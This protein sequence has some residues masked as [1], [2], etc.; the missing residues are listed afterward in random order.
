MKESRKAEMRNTLLIFYVMFLGAFIC[1]DS[2]LAQT[3]DPWTINPVLSLN[4]S[5]NDVPFGVDS[6][7][8]YLKREGVHL[9]FP[10]VSNPALLETPE[11][12]SIVPIRV[13]AW[14]ELGEIQHVSID[15]KHGLA[16]I[17]ARPY[18]GAPDYDLFISSTLPSSRFKKGD[19]SNLWSKAYPLVSLNSS[20]DEVYPQFIQGGL[21]FASNR[22]ETDFDIFFA[23]RH[24]QW[25]SASALD[26]PINSDSD[27]LSLVVLN[28]DDMYVCSN[29]INSEGFDVYLLSRNKNESLAKGFYLEL[30]LD[31][32]PVSG[33]EVKWV[34]T[35]GFDRGA[36]IFENTTDPEGFISLDEL[37]SSRVLSMRIGSIESPVIEGTVVRIMNVNG[38]VVREYAISSSGFLSVD[39]LP[40]D[41]IKDLDLNDLNDLSGLPSRYP[42]IYTLYF[43]LNISTPTS[44]SAGLLELW[45]QNNAQDF[46]V[47]IREFALVLEGHADITG[48][49]DSNENL[50]KK[51]AV[52]FKEWLIS[53]GVH[54]EQVSTR[55]MGARFP[56]KTCPNLSDAFL[57]C[58]PEVHA[59]NRRVELRWEVL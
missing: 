54:A 45:W 36:T 16:V 42:P 43:D 18:P 1:V 7:Y 50:S 37:P 52:W 44:Q 15:E 39:F 38:E 5:G 48:T 20:F 33:V 21:Y 22:N 25:Q 49:T 35:S 34:E 26:F 58:P 31:G 4:T 6:S 27:D 23:P 3:N 46:L 51:R 29:R 59:V 24:L 30:T 55:G 40:L 56:V 9:R 28:D 32:N 2:L 17:S 11:Q 12:V 41:S 13:E 53:K 8:V 14:D 57:D 10:R 47:K 19:T